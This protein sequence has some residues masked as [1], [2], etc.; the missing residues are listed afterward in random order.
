[1]WPQKQAKS[2]KM[3]TNTEFA[4][5]YEGFRQSVMEGK[6]GKTPQIWIY[7]GL[8]QNQNMIHLAV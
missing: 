5:K 2:S 6:L 7:L 3:N 4:C 1:M 8:M